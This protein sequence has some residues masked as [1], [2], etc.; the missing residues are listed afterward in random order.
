MEE[1]QVMEEAEGAMEVVVQDMVIRVADLVEVMVAAM[2]V[3]M[4]CIDSAF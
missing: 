3:N 4:S 1:D 2:G